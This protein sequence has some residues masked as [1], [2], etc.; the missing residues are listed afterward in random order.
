MSEFKRTDI[1]RKKKVVYRDDKRFK[2]F[3]GYVSYEHGF[4][5]ATN[6]FGQSILLNKTLVVSIKD[7]EW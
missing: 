2:V 6:D 1:G 7:L 3:V 5:K 4:L